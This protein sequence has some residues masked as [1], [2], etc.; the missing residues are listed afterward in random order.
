MS[1]PSV[2]TVPAQHTRDED[3]FRHRGAEVTRMEAFFDAAFAFAVTLMVISIDEIPKTSAELLTAAKAIPAF[4]A[5]FL[6]IT[7][8]WRGH[9]DWSRRY[10]LNDR[11]SQRLSLALIFLVLIF[12]YPLRMVFSSFFAW[13]TDGALPA[14]LRFATADDVRLMFLVFALAFGTMGAAMLALYRHAW[15]R[16]E[17]LGLDAIETLVT[18]DALTRWALLPIFSLVSVL[19]TATMP[20]IPGHGWL[21][22]MPGLVFFGLNITQGV[23]GIRLRRQLA[24]LQSA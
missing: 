12:V 6:L 16:R 9:A 19:L 24:A 7:L 1:Y 3:G 17:T 23:L 15:S 5:S 8:F 4:G 11:Y 2:T 10:G 22:A 20:E 13:I 21:L 14:D 18:R